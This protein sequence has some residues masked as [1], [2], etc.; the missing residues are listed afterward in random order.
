MKSFDGLSNPEGRQEEREIEAERKRL[1]HFED[2]L[3]E[4]VREKVWRKMGSREELAKVAMAVA[5]AT[6][7]GIVT[8]YI[9]K[10]TVKEPAKPTVER[11]ERGKQAFVE[12]HV[13]KYL[14]ERN[15]VM[16]VMLYTQSRVGHEKTVIVKGDFTEQKS[17]EVKDRVVPTQIKIKLNNVS[18]ETKLVVPVMGY[19]GKN[20]ERIEVYS[21]EDST[22]IVADLPVF[23]EDTDARKEDPTPIGIDLR[24]I[25]GPEIKNLMQVRALPRALV[26]G[27]YDAYHN[28]S[29]EARFAEMKDGLPNVIAGLEN[30][31]KMFGL[32]PGTAIQKIVIADDETFNANYQVVES[33]TGQGV[34]TINKNI[35]QLKDNVFFHR[36]EEAKWRVFQHEALHAID[37]HFLRNTGTPLSDVFKEVQTNIP[38][39]FLVKLCETKFLNV[40]GGHPWENER[41]FFASVMNGVMASGWE[42]GY[43]K[44]NYE[45]KMWYTEMLHRVKASFEKREALKNTPIMT[46]I[47]ARLIAMQL[48]D[49]DKEEEE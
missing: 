42:K 14:N 46:S 20:G 10:E 49:A 37:R 1:T 24:P 21:G 31:E 18:G 17:I 45:E 36:S 38:E 2:S 19:S 9:G 13:A 32:V 8:L 25:G 43:D 39:A 33:Q 26:I 34:V 11:V 47:D 4:V 15:A 48:H 23:L 29:G 44:L 3:K 30:T 40:I 6:G 7:M 41:E 5:L 12:E 16:N 28:F 35:L 22:I 27:P